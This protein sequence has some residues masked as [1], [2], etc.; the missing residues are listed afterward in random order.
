MDDAKKKNKI[1]AAAVVTGLVVVGFV[2]S[3]VNNRA[4]DR[5]GISGLREILPD[6][7]GYVIDNIESTVYQQLRADSSNKIEYVSGTVRDG[8]S[9]TFREYDG[10]RRGKFIVDIESQERSYVVLYGYDNNVALFCLS[11]PEEI[12]YPESA[13]G[14]STA[15][16]QTEIYLNLLPYQY[17]LDD[18][19]EVTLSFSPGKEVMATVNHC[20]TTIN[21][22]PIIAKAKEWVEGYGMDPSDFTYKVPLSYNDCL[23]K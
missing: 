6:V 23:M 4:S 2:V 8:S 13:C 5:V 14:N 16:D 22:A 11:N 19:R 15:A 7:K 12:I 1:I 9:Y 10:V 17:T 3:F 21:D 18:G 20:G